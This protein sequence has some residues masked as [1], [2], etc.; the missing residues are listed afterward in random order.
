MSGLK[1]Y[2]G[3]TTK[4]RAIR[5][6]M[7]KQEQF[8]ELAEC[9]SVAEVLEYLKNTEAYQDLFSTMDTKDVHRGNIEKLLKKS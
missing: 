2:S 8:L 5:G 6:K 3:I 7:L 4:I 1:S 9:G